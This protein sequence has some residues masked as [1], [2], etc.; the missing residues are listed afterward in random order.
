LIPLMSYPVFR[1]QLRS[2]SGGQGPGEEDVRA[3]WALLCQSEGRRTVPHSLRYID[4]R[5]RYQNARWLP[6]LA[7]SAIPIH[8]CWGDADR[9]A[10]VAIAATLVARHAR[11]AC[12]TRLGAVG[13]FC[14]LEAPERWLD[15]VCGF[16]DPL[17][18][19]ARQPGG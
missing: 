5:R 18:P 12:L 10:P 8:F 6:A 14:Q 15:A 11:R 3:M 7:R 2:A 4:Q 19:G 1:R 17:V 16:W 9:V 13:H